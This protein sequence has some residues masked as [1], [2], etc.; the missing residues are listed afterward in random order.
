M[1]LV[2]SNRIFFYFLLK[3]HHERDDRFFII[4]FLLG[5]HYAGI[6]G[7]SESGPSLERMFVGHIELATHFGALGA[8]S[9]LHF[10]GFATPRT[11]VNQPRNQIIANGS[12]RKSRLSFLYF[13]F[14]TNLWGFFMAGL[15][16]RAT[17]AHAAK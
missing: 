1:A 8:V 4:L 9:L 2:S 12:L 7:L 16:M 3:Q 15:S 17:A 14:F 13:I 5:D 10:Y 6:I 11:N